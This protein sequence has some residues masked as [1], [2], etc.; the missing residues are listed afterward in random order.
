MNDKEPTS[1]IVCHLK[2]SIG[3]RAENTVNQI[4]LPEKVV[5]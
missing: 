5:M 1:L 4:Y 3:C 2:S